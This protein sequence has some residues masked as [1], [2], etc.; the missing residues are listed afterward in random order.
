MLMLCVNLMS[1]VP[2]GGTFSATPFGIWEGGPV[3]RLSLIGRESYCDTR[4]W[5]DYGHGL[6]CSE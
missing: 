3:L 1:L 6:G 2:F 5:T 4:S